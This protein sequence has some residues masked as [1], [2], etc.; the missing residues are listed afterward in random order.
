LQRQR[1]F[2]PVPVRRNEWR[3][4]T[5]GFALLVEGHSPFGHRVASLGW[6]IGPEGY[7]RA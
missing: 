4:N 1:C 3:T 6:S 2:V 5:G 7:A